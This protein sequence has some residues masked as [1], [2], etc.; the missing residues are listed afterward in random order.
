MANA[1]TSHPM[2]ILLIEDNRADARLIIEALRSGNIRHRLT[3]IPDGAEAMEFLHRKGLFTHVPHPDLILL[4]LNLPGR[5][6]RD[7]L[8]E[9]KADYELMTIPVVILTG[10]PSDEDR[11]RSEL[12]LVDGYLRKPVDFGEFTMIV[13]SLT[14][15]WHDDVLLPAELYGGL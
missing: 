10:S 4:D 13:R 9:V 7:L 12:L 5:D 2:E 8:A 11:L 15:H 14:S 6:G 1:L 3:L